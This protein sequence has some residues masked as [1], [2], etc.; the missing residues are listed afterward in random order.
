MSFDRNRSD[1]LFIQALDRLGNLRRNGGMDC[2][3]YAAV[4]NDVVLLYASFADVVDGGKSSGW[5]DVKDSLPEKDIYSHEYNVVIK[6]AKKSTTLYY[7]DGKW[8][9]SEGAV[10]NN[11]RLW[12][13]MPDAPE[14]SQ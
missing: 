10:C 1:A 12:Q 3:D 9:D 11:V 6:G 8:K 4:N 13:S 7:A 14:V 2:A 5:I